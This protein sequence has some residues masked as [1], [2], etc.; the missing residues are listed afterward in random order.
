MIKIRKLGLLASTSAS[1]VLLVVACSSSETGTGTGTGTDSGTTGD[2]AA[3][4]TDGGGGGTDSGGGG[5]TDKC[6][7]APGKY[8]S[9]YTSATGTTT[10]PKP[11]DSSFTISASDGGTTDAGSACTSTT[12][13][14]TCTVTTECTFTTSGYTTKSKTVIKNSNGA[15]TGSQTSKTSKDADG[16]VLSDCTYEFTWTKE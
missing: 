4:N 15:V 16:S 10:C 1:V 12:D 9:H 11:P 2:G 7:L 3:A 14:A 13:T 5:E 6:A 8:T